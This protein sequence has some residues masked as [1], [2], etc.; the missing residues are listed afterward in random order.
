MAGRARC[1]GHG[2]RCLARSVDSARASEVKD[3]L[4][5]LTLIIDKNPP[6]WWRKSSSELQQEQAASAR[7]RPACRID[8]FSHVRAILETEDGSLH[9]ATKFVQ[10]AGGCAAMNAKDPD[11][12]N[13]DL[14]KMLVKTSRGALHR[15]L[16]RS[17][18][19]AQAPELER[20]AARYRYRRLY[21]ARFVKEMTVKRG[22]ISC[23]TWRALFRSPPT[24][25][26]VY[27]RPRR[28]QRTRRLHGR[29]RRHV[30]TAKSQPSGS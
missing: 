4:K 12:E 24:E 2:A 23:S 16:V 27:F 5:S 21:P 19:D 28:R 13:V 30:F 11:T 26:P 10:A 7:S 18:S 8:T 15:A 29:Y 1:A 9:M 25:L 3:K 22:T 17:A 6:R 20:H 14:G